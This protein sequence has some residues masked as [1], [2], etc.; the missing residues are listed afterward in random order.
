MYAIISSSQI[1]QFIP[2]GSQ[3]T[4]NGVDYPSNWIVLSSPAQRAALGIVP[5]IYGLEANQQFYWVSQ[6]DPVYD[7]AQNAVII[8]FTATPKDLDQCKQIAVTN[9]NSTAYNILQPSDYMVV[10][11][12]EEGTT[13]NPQWKTWRQTIRDQAKAGKAAVNA[14]VDVAELA[15]LPPIPW[16]PDPNQPVGGP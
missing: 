1:V 16:A 3:F 8:T 11:S 7:P 14:C 2:D 13:E 6:N 12:V 9:I 15:A 5:V 10:R 4:Y